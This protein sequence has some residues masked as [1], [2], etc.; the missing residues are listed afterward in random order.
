MISEEKNEQQTTGN[1]F[2][3]VENLV[4]RFFTSK[5]IVKALE[6]VSLSINKGEV[7]GLVGE[8]GCGKSVTATSIMDLI[9]DPPGRILS[10]HILI[11]QFD[12]L[13]DLPK[14]AKITVNSETDVRIKRNKWAQKRHNTILSAIRGSKIAMIFQ[15]PS[16]AL[17]PVLT[18]GHQIEETILLHNRVEIANSILRREMIKE[19][20]V[21]SFAKELLS[22]TPDE[23]R[24]R[25]NRW[26]QDYGVQTIESSM[27]DLFFA[28]TDFE[29]IHREMQNLVMEEKVDIDLQEIAQARD[30]YKGQRALVDLQMKQMEAERVDNTSGIQEF[31]LEIQKLKR[32]LKTTF[33]SYNIRRKLFKKRMDR[34]FVKEA[35]RRAIELLS[36]VNIAG[37][38]RVVDS[39]PH[40]LSGGM[41]QR[42]MI[43]MALASNP[44]MLIADEPTTA[45]DVTTQAQI[46]DLI[47]DLNKV[48]GSAV[49]FITHDLAVIA[50]MCKR[51]AVMYAGNIVEEASVGEIFKNPKHPYTVGL[52]K[53]VPAANRQYEKGFKLE[54]ISGNVPNLISPPTGCRFNPRCHLV[55]DR[56]SKDKPLLVD[57]G[58]GH[59]VAC[60]LYSE[61][62]AEEAA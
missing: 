61:Q 12:I 30:F 13:G 28:T 9:P 15:E 2:V 4:T 56:C 3:R 18:I 54:S 35:R 24:K 22:L 33:G 47:I 11:D 39:Y 41:Q 49:L 32:E 8:S 20:E 40:E 5:G 34:P 1:E 36:L 23:R 52:M 37:A 50:Q 44:Q 46:L 21:D 10:G 6:G 16:L 45:L 17:N 60:F 55:M 31:E 19:S 43:A 57:L 25:I 38:E 7:L 58:E 14:L 51:V 26:V 59:K 48:V 27:N 62:M 53:S 29:F 42:A